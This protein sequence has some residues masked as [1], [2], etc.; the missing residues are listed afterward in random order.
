MYQER[1]VIELWPIGR[2][3]LPAYGLVLRGE[4]P[5]GLVGRILPLKWL[6]LRFVCGVAIDAEVTAILGEVAAPPTK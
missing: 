1:P 5:S 6:H 4:F 2:L 3:E